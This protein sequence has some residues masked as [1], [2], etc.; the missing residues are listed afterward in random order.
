[1][2]ANTWEFGWLGN[3]TAHRAI[4][5][6]SLWLPV[7]TLFLGLFNIVIGLSRALP[8]DL[9]YRLTVLNLT[10]F[11]VFTLFAAAFFV[12]LPLF[13]GVV[14]TILFALA[15]RSLAREGTQESAKAAV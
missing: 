5:G 14:A 12:Y 2:M 6:F 9:F 10:A 11:V 8:R 4:S 15:A 7:S 13:N 3:T 1:M